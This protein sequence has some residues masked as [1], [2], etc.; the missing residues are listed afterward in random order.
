M[1]LFVITARGGSKGIPGKNIKKLGGKPLI[2]YSI[3]VAREFVPDSQIC[4][5]TDDPKI[6][7]VATSLGLDVPFL[8][9][10]HLASDTAGSYEVL[11]HALDYWEKVHGTFKRLILLQPTSPFRKAQHVREAMDAFRP[12]DDMIISTC[13]ASANPYYTL[14]EANQSGYLE[15]S[16]KGMVTRRQDAPMVHEANGAIYV[17]DTDSLRKSPLNEMKNVRPYLMDRI[18]S[19][20]LDEPLDWKWAEFLLE[21]GLV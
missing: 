13:E 20:D 14:Y 5:T 2:Q 7:A 15:R 16:K 6:K 18:S 12:G 1:D 3:D 17:I 19:T 8:R 9:P 21:E 11:L 10:A 4:L